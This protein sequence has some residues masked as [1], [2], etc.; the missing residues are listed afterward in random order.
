M[1]LINSWTV[2]RSMSQVCTRPSSPG[3][4]ADSGSLKVTGAITGTT[5]RT[6]GN[7]GSISADSITNSNIY[8]GVAGPTVD[9]PDDIGDFTGLSTI[10]SVSTR[11][12]SNSNLAAAGL[13]RL[14][15]GAVDTDNAGT[16]FGVSS[17]AITSLT[18]TLDPT[19][20][21]FRFRNLAEQADADAQIAAQ[22][23]NLGNF[24]VRVV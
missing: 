1:A 3:G 16:S 24:L 21:R 19:G 14:N 2:A 23:L 4:T 7:I 12:F 8:A 5:V 9:L 13:Q 10:K 22:G 18:G 6:I 11:T 15:L 17:G 20:Q